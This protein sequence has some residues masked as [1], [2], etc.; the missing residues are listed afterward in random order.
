M[1]EEL[2][3]IIE[4]PAEQSAEAEAI[5]FEQ[6]SGRYIY[7]IAAGGKFLDEN[8]FGAL[9][10]A[11]EK[12]GADIVHATRFIE[13]RDGRFSIV[14][15]DPSIAGVV[16]DKKIF[17]AEGFHLMPSLNLYRKDFLE[18]HQLKFPSGYAFSYAAFNLADKIFFVDDYFYVHT[19]QP[20]AVDDDP[21]GLVKNIKR[22]EF[23][24]GWLVTT[25][26]KKLWNVQL[27]L[28]AEF[29]RICQKHNL[30]WFAYAGTLLGA[31]R[32][33]GFVPWDDDVDL[34]MFRP[35]YERLKKII[36]SELAP[37]YSVD[38]WYDYAF[39]GERN[40]N[41]LP[42]LS[43][44]VFES[45]AWW[46]STACYF[47]IRDNRT[48]MI[49]WSDRPNVNQGICIDVFPIDP[50]PP[51]IDQ[52][53]AD[54]FKFISDLM[55]AVSAPDS[56]NTKKM[57][58]RDKKYF[59]ALL[60]KPFRD[61]ALEYEKFLAEHWFESEYVAHINSIFAYRGSYEWRRE[62]WDELVE[63]P[64]E[65]ISL[66]APRGYDQV[67]KAH[68]GDWREMVI[69]HSHVAVHSADVSYREYFEGI[70]PEILGQQFQ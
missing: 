18:R 16:E 45:N 65:K 40:P 43:R 4:L 39:E 41:G 24:S 47:K 11:A 36:A 68:Y 55:L 3:T 25:Q 63:L 20:P 46:P 28:I 7:F 10:L 34:A 70:A 48:S 29:A 1:E 31:A 6:I 54:D 13:Q 15:D 5:P 58:S 66:P 21:A 50:A 8:G 57:S 67:L 30:K 32:H 12:T 35:D 2:V 9:Y 64:F 62:W 19:P 38:F 14:S 56:L 22:D 33:R 49:E 51:F 27:H 42:T 52:K 69:T 17:S 60:K 53:R 44:A 26:R 37:E 61:R 59:K 23:R